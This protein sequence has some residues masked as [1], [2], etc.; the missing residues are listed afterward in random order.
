[1][2]R[3]NVSAADIVREAKDDA[4]GGPK[5][6]WAGQTVYVG[7]KAVADWQELAQVADC[8]RV[9]AQ[10]VKLQAAGRERV[11]NGAEWLSAAE[12]AARGNLGQD[13][14]A[15]WQQQGR[16]FSIRDGARELYPRYLLDDVFEPIPAVAE[17]VRVLSGYT[18]QGIAAW[19]ESTSSF[20]GGQR[21][22][23]L[24]APEPQ[25][26]IAAARDAVEAE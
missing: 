19:F 15:G 7:D 17:I 9:N 5:P 20:L 26:V 24:L 10:R 23:E 3:K 2:S 1:V 13:T 14:I 6:S 4:S 12:I 11:L 21:P 16:V 8:A 22:R 18:A 25:R